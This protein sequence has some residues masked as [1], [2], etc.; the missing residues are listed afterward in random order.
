MCNGYAGT[1]LKK[2]LILAMISTKIDLCL[3]LMTNVLNKYPNVSENL[4]YLSIIVPTVVL[5]V[6][7]IRIIIC[8]ESTGVFQYK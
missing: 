8:V 1:V 4:F 6:T 3:I 7:V 5:F 2:L